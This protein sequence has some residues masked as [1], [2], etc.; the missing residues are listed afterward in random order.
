M[1]SAHQYRCTTSEAAMTIR[2]GSGK[3]T[4]DDANM[5]SKVGMTKISRIATAGTVTPTIMAG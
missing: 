4:P 5:F 1:S 3:G 2:V